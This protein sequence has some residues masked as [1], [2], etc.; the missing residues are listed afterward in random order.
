M[1]VRD[2][3]IIIWIIENF[4][5]KIINNNNNNNALNPIHNEAKHEENDNNNNNTHNKILQIQIT[6]VR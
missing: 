2:F 4:Q 6:H 5:C 3:T 1:T